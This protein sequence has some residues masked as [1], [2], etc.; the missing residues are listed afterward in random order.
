MLQVCRA[1]GWL[2][3]SR[4]QGEPW[5]EY[6]KARLWIRAS[7]FGLFS[8]LKVT[9]KQLKFNPQNTCKTPEHHEW[10]CSEWLPQSGKSPAGDLTDDTE[11]FAGK[12]Q[13]SPPAPVS[14]AAAGSPDP[15]KV[16]H[17]KHHDGDDFL[18]GQQH[19]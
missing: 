9:M 4:K 7:A 13:T 3:A 15:H 8:F 16:F 17:P 1:L 12:F 5:D 19:H 10:K 14:A 2:Q 18:G 6:K 11:R